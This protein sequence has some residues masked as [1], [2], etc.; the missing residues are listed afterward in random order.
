MVKVDT[1]PADQNQTNNVYVTPMMTIGKRPVPPP[2]VVVQPAVIS[3]STQTSQVST[4]SSLPSNQSQQEKKTIF[5]VAQN[6]AE[7]LTPKLPIAPSRTT[8]P[9]QKKKTGPS[10]QQIVGVLPN[11]QNQGG[12]GQQAPFGLVSIQSSDTDKTVVDQQNT[13]HDD[14]R[15]FEKNI[16]QE[17]NLHDPARSFLAFAVV[18]V[19]VCLIAGGFFLKMGGAL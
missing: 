15:G 8:S 5:S 14:E 6:L 7:K 17:K 18:F 9:A 2:P 10:P 4:S 1:D 19:V 3:S 16:P 13:K 12:D 11:N